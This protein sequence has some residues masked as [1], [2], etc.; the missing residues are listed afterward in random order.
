MYGVF[1]S[2][3]SQSADMNK[4]CHLCISAAYRVC[5]HFSEAGAYWQN[6]LCLEI[7]VLSWSLKVQ[8]IFESMNLLTRILANW[9]WARAQAGVAAAANKH[10]QIYNQPIPFSN[11]MVCAPAPKQEGCWTSTFGALATHSVK[12]TEPWICLEENYLSRACSFYWSSKEME[13]EQICVSGPLFLSLFKSKGSL[14][15]KQHI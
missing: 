1:L 7:V 4:H 3:V 10:Q 11:F 12:E 5:R 8:V 2:C 13:Q 15:G 14:Y 6:K 9:S